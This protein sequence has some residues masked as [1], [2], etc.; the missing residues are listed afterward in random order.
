MKESTD[1]KKGKTIE[2]PKNPQEY[3]YR[4]D[5]QITMSAA[6]FMMLYRANDSALKE[7]MTANY[8]TITEWVST[9]TRITVDTELSDTEK[10]SGQY[11]EVM[12]VAKT[13]AQSNVQESTAE[14]AFPEVIQVKDALI[15]IHQAMVESGVAIHMSELQ[16]EAKNSA[17][18]E[19]KPEVE[20][21]GVD[22]DQK[23]TD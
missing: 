11:Q 19:L 1:Q 12:S 16:A 6:V 3:S 13:Y 8:P 20:D 15:Q 21:L 23:A 14:W 10:A 18:Q 4:G 17:A 9:A 7:A 5:E 2:L 22:V